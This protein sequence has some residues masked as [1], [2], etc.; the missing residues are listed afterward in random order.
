MTIWEPDLVGDNRG[1]G[2]F[3]ERIVLSLG[4]GDIK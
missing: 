1:T 2:D 4:P 3:N